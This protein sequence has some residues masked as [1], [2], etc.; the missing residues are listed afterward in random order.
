M[1][2]I[3][4]S[5]LTIT[6]VLVLSIGVTSAYFTSRATANPIV[7]PSGTVDIIVT[8]QVA[9]GDDD[10]WP[11]SSHIF[12][13]IVQ[14][15]GTLPVNLKGYFSG[16]WSNPELSTDA[17]S[18]S[19]FRVL[20]GGNW[21]PMPVGGLMIGQETELIDTFTGS[22]VLASGEHKV[23]RITMGLDETAGDEYQG[24]HLTLGLHVAAKQIN[25]GADWPAEY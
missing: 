13:F 9:D 6:T 20:S 25:D 4:K 16:E 3:I 7:F 18:F 23:Y 21:H 12:E 24:E 1:K 17:I 15:T 11:G 22:N 19:D 5:L 14:N 2:S 8:Q 10:L